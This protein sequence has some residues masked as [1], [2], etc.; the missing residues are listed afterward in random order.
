MVY[1]TI[2]VQLLI[3]TTHDR[4]WGSC[5]RIY[6][7]VYRVTVNYQCPVCTRACSFIRVMQKRMCQRSNL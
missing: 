1:Y 5:T 2:R 6:N 4:V 3:C 7:S